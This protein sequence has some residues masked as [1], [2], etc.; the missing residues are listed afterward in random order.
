MKE[1]QILIRISGKDRIGLTASI[2]AILAK[3]DAQILDL[4]QAVIHNTLS[5]GILIR[6]DESHSGQVMKELLFKTTELGSISIG[7]APISDEDYEAWAGRQGRNRYILTIIGRTLSAGQIQAATDV[8]SRHGLNIDAIKR[9]TGRMSIMHPE[10][11]VRACVEFSLRG[12]LSADDKKAMQ[13]DLMAMG[14]EVGVDFSFQKDDMYRRMRRLI[15]FDMDSTLIQ[16]EC[17]DE[18]AR[19][20][21]VYD[22]VAAITERAMRGEI[23]FKESFTERVALLK[24]LD[25]SVMQDIAEHLPITEGTDRLMSV[26]KTCGYKIAIL[27]G[28][29]TFF[30]EYLQRKYGIDYVYANELE[31][32]EDGKLTGRYLGDVVDGR[33]KADLLKLIAQTEKVNL[34][35]TI[36]VGDGANDLP[37]INEAGLG[38]AFHAKPRVKQSARQSIS[39]IGLDGVLYFIGFKDSQL[40]EQGKL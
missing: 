19:R 23:D 14:T 32:G 39:T 30:G 5:M 36:A 6:I 29:F 37:M 10:K 15:C 24:G 21:G 16:A 31:V 8:I 17:I 18:L 27:S 12:F 33:R 11:N 2:M 3:Y 26:L 34:A 28:G 4:G 40:G 20:H 7:F 9:L 35:Q 22:Q 1:E 38:I 13:K 25:I